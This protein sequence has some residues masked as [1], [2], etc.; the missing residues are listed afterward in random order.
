MFTECDALKR[1]PGV[2][3]QS[4]PG[5]FFLGCVALKSLFHSP[6]RV[7]CVC[8]VL[9]YDVLWALGED[10]GFAV[11]SASKDSVYICDFAVF[12]FSKP[13][14]EMWSDGAARQFA[15]TCGLETSVTQLPWLFS[16]SFFFKLHIIVVSTFLLQQ[17]FFCSVSLKKGLFFK[18]DWI[19]TSSHTMED[20]FIYGL[21]WGWINKS[22]LTA[23]QSAQWTTHRITHRKS[24]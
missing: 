19:V 18:C 22:I 5:F 14:I 17:L 21:C 2:S 13:P 16:L 8:R 10:S 15:S 3:A 7:F 11:P 20:N 1:L 9:D 12:F 24:I 4:V 6:Y 23:G